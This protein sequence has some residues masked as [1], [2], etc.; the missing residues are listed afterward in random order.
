MG[1][2]DQTILGNSESICENVINALHP[3]PPTMRRCTALETRKRQMSPSVP[4]Q[5]MEWQ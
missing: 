1:H 3:R 2:R 4:Y 5:S